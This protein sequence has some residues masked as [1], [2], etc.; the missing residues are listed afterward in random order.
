MGPTRFRLLKM[1]FGYNRT[2]KQDPGMKISGASN[3]S[4]FDVVAQQTQSLT[5][6]E[7]QYAAS[8]R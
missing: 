6:R 3:I 4:L 1:V 5:E 7:A 2:Q 8:A